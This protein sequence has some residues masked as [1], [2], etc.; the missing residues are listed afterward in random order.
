MPKLKGYF[1]NQ[2]MQKSKSF[3]KTYSLI[4]ALLG[5]FAVIAQFIILLD[6]RTTSIPEAIIRFFSYFTIL[7]NIIVAL[8]FSSIAL[9]GNTKWGRFFNTPSTFTAITVYIIV[10]GAVYNII[11]RKIWHPVG[12]Q[13]PVDELLHSAI[14]V[15]SVFFW[16]FFVP[17]ITLQW[18]N[19]FAWLLYPLI[20]GLFIA[21]RGALSDFYP[22]PFINVA[23]IGY[24]RVLLNGLVLAVLFLG[25][26]LFLIA[27]GKFLSR[28]E[29]AAQ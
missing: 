26:S 21:I 13:I 8:T 28:K 4:T 1:P 24:P 23:V 15:L 5:W 27:A 3:I 2:F 20:Y 14:P 25:L 19:S 9:Q 12:L 18:K 10:V 22:Y 29:S 6:N 17:K 11:L 7:T 16:L